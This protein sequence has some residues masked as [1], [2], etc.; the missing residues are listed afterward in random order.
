MKTLL[1]AVFAVLYIQ[2][3]LG[4]DPHE[5]S[6]VVCYWNSTAYER[7]GGSFFTSFFASL[8]FMLHVKSI[9]RTF[10]ILSVLNRFLESWE[11]RYQTCHK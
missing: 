6:K 7:Q 11:Y 5:H 3:V 2:A 1:S 4:V 8:T 10:I 9:G